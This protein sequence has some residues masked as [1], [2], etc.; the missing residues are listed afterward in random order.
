MET[1]PQLLTKTDTANLLGVSER[2]LDRWHALRKGP[3]RVSAGRKVLY[4][5]AAV[6]AWL[7]ANEEHPLGTFAGG[8][9][10]A[11]GDT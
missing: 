4:R 8:Y 2:T 7:S 11:G 1:K 5:M 6:S 10:A 3:A 9:K